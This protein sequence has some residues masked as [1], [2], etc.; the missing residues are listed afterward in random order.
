M[1]RAGPELPAP[2]QVTLTSTLPASRWA[3][4]EW[5]PCGPRAPTRV[6]PPPGLAVPA[7]PAPRRP[8]DKAPFRSLRPHGKSPRG[9]AAAA[10]ARPQVRDSAPLTR[11]SC[12]APAGAATPR[13]PERSLRQAA[14]PGDRGELR[15]PCQLPPPQLGPFKNENFLHLI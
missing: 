5:A 11:C 12:P 14:C 6:P 9:L 13:P 3:S 15:S 2:L 4:G 1:R 8:A 7:V 10:S